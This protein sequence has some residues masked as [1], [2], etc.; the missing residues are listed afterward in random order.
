MNRPLTLAEFEP[1][2]P[3]R[4]GVQFRG[5]A[6][7][8]WRVTTTPHSAIVPEAADDISAV[9]DA[10][11]NLRRVRSS[12][13]DPRAVKPDSV[14]LAEQALLRQVGATEPERMRVSIDSL[15]LDLSKILD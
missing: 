6:V 5:Y 8:R 15:A 2:R 12:I 3:I 4:E 9:F 7:R 1:Y 10:K 14:R 11:E 13:L